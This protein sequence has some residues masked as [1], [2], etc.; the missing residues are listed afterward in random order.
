MTCSQTQSNPCADCL[1][2]FECMEQRGRCREYKDL[3]EVRE[4]IAMLNKKAV[5]GRFA[6]RSKADTTD[7]RQ[8][9]AGDKPP[10]GGQAR[11]AARRSRD[12]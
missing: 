7:N 2:L 10:F 6:G 8:G 9:G 11:E 1:H 12:A 4:E 5:L 3:E